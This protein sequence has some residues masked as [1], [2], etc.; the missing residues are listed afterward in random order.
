MYEWETK[1]HKIWG[2]G[3]SGNPIK[4]SKKSGNLELNIINYIL[5]VRLK[6]C[7]RILFQGQINRTREIRII[8]TTSGQWMVAGSGPRC[9]LQGISVQKF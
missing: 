1:K 4:Y 3:E 8:E 9:N 5:K 2:G 7:F 6:L